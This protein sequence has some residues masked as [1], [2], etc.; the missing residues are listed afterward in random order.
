MPSPEE[1]NNL[2]SKF[3]LTEADFA[4]VRRAGQL[5]EKQLPSFISDWYEW[6]SQHEEY[7]FFFGGNPDSLAR[8]QR[9]QLQHWQTFFTAVVDKDYVQRCRYIG[10][11]H[12]RIELHN[13]IYL[14][15]ISKA[16]SLL[17]GRLNL[18]QPSPSQLPMLIDS[19]Q[20]FAFMEAYLTMEEIVRIQ[21]EKLAQHSRAL[22]EISTPV[23]PIWDGILLLPLLGIIDSARTQDVM[24]K[25]L[26]KIAETRAKVFVLDISGVGAVDTAVA[27]QLIKITKATRLMGC[28]AIISGISPAIARTVV[29]LGVSVWDVRTTSTLRDAFEIALKIIGA[30][31][32]VHALAAGAGH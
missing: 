21:S 10:Q 18:L 17:N 24:N 29:E 25:S 6:L 30:E 31:K 22:L 7:Q 2:L 1:I 14:A 12:A 32:A 4:N 13:D 11:V 8:V 9:Q 15:G 26:A 3:D 28:E 23:T 20:K 27:N 5:L 16:V 19:V